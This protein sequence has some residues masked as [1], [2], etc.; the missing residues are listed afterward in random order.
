MNWA[1]ASLGLPIALHVTSRNA[2]LQHTTSQWRVL[3]CI[4]G[5]GA[6]RDDGDSTV[7]DR[8]MRRHRK[9]ADEQPVT[10]AWRE[11]NGAAAGLAQRAPD[12]SIT[13]PPRASYAASCPRC[14]ELIAIG[15][16]IRRD[17]DFVHAR[18][19]TKP[20]PRSRKVGGRVSPSPR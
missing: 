18:G 12:S 8:E 7:S 13:E 9:E 14:S 19:R 4:E 16:E 2:P 11:L 15:Q 20:D 5:V 3:K 6:R 1:V 10:S 17:R